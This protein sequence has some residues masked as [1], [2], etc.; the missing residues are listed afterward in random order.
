MS[1]PL[2]QIPDVTFH[3]NSNDTFLLDGVGSRTGRF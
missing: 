3:Q 2:P 1:K